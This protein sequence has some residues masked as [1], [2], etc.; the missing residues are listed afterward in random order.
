MDRK[1]LGNVQQTDLTE[2]RINDDFLFW[3]KTSG[4]NWLLAV[5]VV[6]CLV[7]GWNWWQNRSAQA[8]DLAWAELDAADLPSSLKDVAVKHADV[9]A[10]ASFALLN[11]GDRFLQSVVTGQRFDREATATDAQL[12]PAM[13]LEWLNEADGLYTEVIKNAQANPKA[14]ASRGFEVSALFGRAAVAESKG[15]VAT[16][17]TSLE[18]AQALAG[19]E[20]P[21]VAGQAKARIETLGVISSPYPIPPAPPVAVLPDGTPLKLPDGTSPT[22]ADAMRL[23][24]S[25]VAKSAAQP[26][27]APAPTEVTPAES[28]PAA[29]PVPAPAPAPVPAPAPAP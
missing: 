18:A 17:K 4:P 23:L 5:L 14:A 13:R 2:G 29:A 15:D 26:V 3:L 10:V 19:T 12:T 22:E 25:D 27:N 21:W 16:A 1:R 11:A 6:A 20:Y 8:R 28:A 9:G 7:M 24:M